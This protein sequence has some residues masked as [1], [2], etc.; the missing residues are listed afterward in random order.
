MEGLYIIMTEEERLKQIEQLIKEQKKDMLSRHV[1]RPRKEINISNEKL[2]E[3]EERGKI[4]TK[5]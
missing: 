2:L 4:K 5:Y 3:L 1:T